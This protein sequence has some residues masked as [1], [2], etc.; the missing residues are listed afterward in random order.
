MNKCYWCGGEGK[1][2]SKWRKRWRCEQHVNSCPAKRS[3]KTKEKKNKI[4]PE[5]VCHM[6]G[7]DAN[8][9]DL[10]GKPRC[11]KRAYDCPQY[12]INFDRSETMKKRWAEN[13][14]VYRDEERL[15]K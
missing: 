3:G 12:S 13:D 9:K 8:F 15:K 2:Y 10:L 11:T 5:D 6:C 14:S 1:F 4:N 7:G